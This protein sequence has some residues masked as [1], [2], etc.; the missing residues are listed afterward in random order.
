MLIVKGRFTRKER[1]SKLWIRKG[2]LHQVNL[3]TKLDFYKTA[4]TVKFGVVSIR[5][6]MLLENILNDLHAIV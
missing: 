4:V 6:W 1:A 3:W 5:V 2:K